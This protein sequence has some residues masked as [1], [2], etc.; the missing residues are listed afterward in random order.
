MHDFKKNV[1]RSRD[2]S[3]RLS[4]GIEFLMKKNKIKH[5]SGIGRFKSKNSIEINNNDKVSNWH[6]R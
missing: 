1:K 2:I 5:L 4:K 3:Q 6:D